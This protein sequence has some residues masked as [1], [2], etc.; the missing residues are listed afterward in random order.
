MAR[1]AGHGGID[2]HTGFCIELATAATVV[3]A[4]LLSVP[5][6]STQ[7]QVGAIVC[8]GLASSAGGARGMRWDLLGRVALSW[9]LT[10]P[11][12]AL[13]S[14]AAVAAMRPLILR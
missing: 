10:L 7:C 4:S 5:V 6:S 11:A 9:V 14:V 1:L 12:S 3:L 13:F 2:Y 8:V